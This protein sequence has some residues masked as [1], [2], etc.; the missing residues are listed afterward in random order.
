MHLYCMYQTSKIIYSVVGFT[1]QQQT[2]VPITSF[3]LNT[4]LTKAKNVVLYE[5]LEN[6]LG[7]KHSKV[8]NAILAQV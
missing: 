2:S 6:M 8:D 4:R 7:C 1:P 3:H 5:N